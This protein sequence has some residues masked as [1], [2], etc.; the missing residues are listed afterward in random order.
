VDEELCPFGSFG[1]W[2]LARWDENGLDENLPDFR[3][4][5]NWFD[6]NAFPYA[7][8]DLNSRIA[9]TYDSQSSFLKKVC[10]MIDF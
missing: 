5:A 3:T 4:S 2:L 6:I 9:M 10:N 7:H 1:F 8:D